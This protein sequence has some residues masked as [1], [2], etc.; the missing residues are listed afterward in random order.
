MHGKDSQILRNKK[1]TRLLPGQDAGPL[2]FGVSWS[3]A[4]SSSG[5]SRISL[6]Y[7]VTYFFQGHSLVLTLPC[8]I[9]LGLASWLKSFWGRWAGTQTRGWTNPCFPQHVLT[10]HFLAQSSSEYLGLGFVWLGYAQILDCHQLRR[11]ISSDLFSHACFPWTTTSWNRCNQR[12]NQRISKF[13]H[14]N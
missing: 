1:K 4:S 10:L 9:W 7:P 12:I 3:T 2:Q 5:T 11:G 6:L 8:W 14:S 13:S